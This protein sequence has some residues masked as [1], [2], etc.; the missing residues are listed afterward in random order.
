M[1]E[2]ILTIPNYKSIILKHIVLDYNGTLAK[3]GFLKDETKVLLQQLTQKY[4]I[5]VVT[6]DTFGSVKPEL[7][8]F[9]IRVKVLQT[10]NHTLEKADYVKNL[11]SKKCAAVGNGNNDAQML[12]MAELGIALL[13]DEGCSTQTLM[14]SDLFCKSIDDALSLFLNTKRLIAT[15]RQ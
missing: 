7:R 1:K 2:V 9:D 6:A 10:D 12:K 4:K 14:N 3:D 5:H 15:L 13:G 11:D 8:G